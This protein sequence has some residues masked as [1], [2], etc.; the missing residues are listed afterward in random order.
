MLGRSCG[1]PQLSRVPDY[2]RVDAVVGV[3]KSADVLGR[4][5]DKVPVPMTRVDEDSTEDSTPRAIRVFAAHV[6]Y[7]AGSAKVPA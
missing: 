1:S 4:I 3:E 7:A 2:L 6:E 5:R